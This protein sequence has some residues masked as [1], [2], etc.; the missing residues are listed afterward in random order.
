MI[1]CK[2]EDSLSRT[3]SLHHGLR[4]SPDK[5]GYRKLT[6]VEQLADAASEGKTISAAQER[7]HPQHQAE[8]EAQQQT[9]HNRKIKRRAATLN[10]DVA[11]QAPQSKRQS[12]GA[13][14]KKQQRAH[15]HQNHAEKQQ[16]FA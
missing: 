9:G 6:P 4:L 16:Q 13:D 2:I 7:H 3:E 5:S 1:V 8:H 10:H 12:A 15:S 14:A 11:R